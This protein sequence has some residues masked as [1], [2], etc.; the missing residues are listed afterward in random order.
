MRGRGPTS[1][2]L[3]R[4]WGGI[5]ARGGGAASARKCERREHAHDPERAYSPVRGFRH[6]LSVRMKRGGEDERDLKW[7]HG[8]LLTRMMAMQ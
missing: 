6:S 8:M 7:R 5:C 4:P 1:K 2:C 3:Q